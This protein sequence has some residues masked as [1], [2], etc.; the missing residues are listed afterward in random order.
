MK[1][2]KDFNLPKISV[3][4]ASFNSQSRSFLG[5]CLE[6]IKNQEYKGEVE[7]IVVDGG[8]TDESVSIS[9][10]LGAKVIHNPQVTELGF[11]GGKN[12]G[13]KN[14][15]GEFIAIVDADNILIGKDYLE[16]MIRPFLED[17]EISMTVPLPY[18][19]SASD[20]TMICRYFCLI[21]RKLWQAMMESGYTNES[22]VKVNPSKIVVSNGAIIRRSVLNHI[23]GWDYDTE[24]GYRL[25]NGGFG[26]FGIVNSAERLHI[27]MI[28]LIDVWKKFKR[29]IINQ[30]EDRDAK[31]VSQKVIN[32]YKE[33]PLE[34]IREE[35]LTPLKNITNGYKRFFPMVLAVFCTKLALG[36]YYIVLYHKSKIKSNR[37]GFPAS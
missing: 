26:T 33:K 30:I 4:V 20:C 8:S 18:M 34:F 9:L 10:S 2:N 32:Y 6:S 25:I 37:H 22:W 17:E 36:L 12:L 3:I 21:E 14:S 13:I 5:R 28:H 35:F 16:K 24:V 23:G 31:I 15:T 11:N 19:P 29:R 1:P 27:E 7:L